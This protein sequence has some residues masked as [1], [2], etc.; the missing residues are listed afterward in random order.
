MNWSKLKPE[1]IQVP[2]AIC[3]AIWAHFANMPFLTLVFTLVTVVI[4]LGLLAELRQFE[5]KAEADAI[6]I[7]LTVSFVG[8]HTVESNLV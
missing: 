8:A 5:Y 7:A 6:L 3:I 1:Y 2:L 4:G